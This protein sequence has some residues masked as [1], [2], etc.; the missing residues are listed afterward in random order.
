MVIPN[1]NGQKPLV[2]SLRE[3][4]ISLND[5]PLFW[6][7]TYREVEKIAKW[8]LKALAGGPI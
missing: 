2:L 4:E 6:E 7:E 3:N 1:V 8:L 5:Y